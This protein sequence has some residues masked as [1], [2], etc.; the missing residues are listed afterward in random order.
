VTSKEKK[1]INIK[2]VNNLY[3]TKQLDQ[4]NKKLVIGNQNSN[5]S[6]STH[7][8]I[9]QSKAD[10]SQEINSAMKQLF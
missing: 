4:Q 7:A 6:M 8:N 9:S 1:E 10:P 2:E 3:A 5:C